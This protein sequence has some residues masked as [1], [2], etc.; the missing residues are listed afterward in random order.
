M[1][2]ELMNEMNK[3]MDKI[4]AMGGDDNAMSDWVISRLGEVYEDINKGLQK[5]AI[6]EAIWDE[7]TDDSV[8]RSNELW[9]ICNK[10]E[11]FEWMYEMIKNI[12]N[13]FD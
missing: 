5:M 6:I 10:D 1:K 7:W 2:N 12:E 4:N 3:A 8:T 9:D 13:I 11:D